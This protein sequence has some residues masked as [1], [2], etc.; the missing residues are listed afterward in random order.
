MENNQNKQKIV[1][2]IKRD[3][4]TEGY[5]NFM[6]YDMDSYE[7][8]FITRK[9]DEMNLINEA[10]VYYTRE[11]KEIL[12]DKKLRELLK[13]CDQIVISGFFYYYKVCCLFPNA[14]MKK[15]YIQFWGGDFYRFRRK[16]LKLRIEKVMVRNCIKRCRCVLVL[17]EEDYKK[18]TEIFG[19]KIRYLI[20]PMVNCSKD[21]IDYTL[22]RKESSNSTIRILIGNSADPE[23][24]HMDAFEMLQHISNENIEII[25]PLSYGKD[26]YREEVIEAGK[27]IFGDKFTPVTGY[28]SKSDYVA[29][30][31]ECTVGV[32]NSNRQ[33][34][35]GNIRILSMLGKK[36]YLRKGTAMWDYFLREGARYEDIQELTKSSIYDIM[37]I[38]KEKIACNIAVHER[39]AGMHKKRWE[40]VFADAD[41]G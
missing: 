29:Y 2:I 8:Y 9:G 26:A 40:T 21:E 34:A 7:H 10:H 4:F 14:L 6:K 33:H 25:C 1:H 20:A 3:K 35:L 23:N 30:L 36:V 16:S 22:F 37:R 38:D 31:S 18:M 27:R 13:S 15:T 19:C 11:D 24:A 32:F 17:I 28:M 39:L 5:I 41:R 12:S